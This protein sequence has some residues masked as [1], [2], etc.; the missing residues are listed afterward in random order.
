[1]PA[2]GTDQL[3]VEGVIV[4]DFGGFEG[5]LSGDYY[6]QVFPSGSRGE[7]WRFFEPGTEEKHLV[8]AAG[9]ISE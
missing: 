5:K 4:D 7:D 9:R 3:V 1:M 6:L 8:I 2:N